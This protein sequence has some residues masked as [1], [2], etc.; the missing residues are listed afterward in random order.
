MGV[1]DGSKGPVAVERDP[2][3]LLARLRREGVLRTALEVGACG[4]RPVLPTGVETLDR[5]LGGGLPRGRI[6]ELV[7]PL[8][9]GRTAFLL[10]VLAAATAR[11][12]QTALIDPADAFDASSAAAVGVALER[13]LWVRPGR[14][15]DAFR[16]ADLV[17]GAGGF[18]VVALDLTDLRPGAG[19]HRR[20]PWPRLS[21]RAE[22]SSA[23]LLALGERR[24]A[25]T[26]AALVLGLRRGSPGWAGGAGAPLLLE[27]LDVCIEILRSKVG[28]A[29]EPGAA[30]TCGGPSG[31]AAGPVRWGGGL[32][33]RKRGRDAA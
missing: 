10:Q 13:V 28:R 11:G 19:T 20:V 18:G 21:L 31:S 12:E 4:T 22:R 33:G 30:S 7:G 14:R 1:V 23:V 27:R 26:F 3:A 8:S 16:A 25:G 17:L 29:G 6:V 15:L 24:E 5:M 32:P 9:S 2:Q